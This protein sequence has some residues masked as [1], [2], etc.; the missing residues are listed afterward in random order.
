MKTQLA[1]LCCLIGLTLPSHGEEVSV[2]HVGSEPTKIAS[3]DN[4]TGWVLI[5][6][7]FRHGTLT[8]IGGAIVTFEP[9]A[10]T[11]WHS[12]PAGQTLIVLSGSGLVQEWGHA[13][14]LTKPGDVVWIPPNVKHWH[15]ASAANSMSHIALSQSVDGKTVTWIEPVTD[16]HYQ[17]SNKDNRGF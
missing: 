15:G 8:P 16:E 11:F 2:S 4:F 7:S 14:K 5:D 12:H 6:A 3:R 9:G 10:R 1:C 13:A 17:T